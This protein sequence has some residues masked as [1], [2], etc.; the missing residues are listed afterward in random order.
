MMKY[1]QRSNFTIYINILLGKILIFFN[2]Q[3]QVSIIETILLFQTQFQGIK[4]IYI[5]IKFRLITI[6]ST[7]FN[8]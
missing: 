8:F 2:W 1:S 6:I 5:K 4:I 7:G 3:L